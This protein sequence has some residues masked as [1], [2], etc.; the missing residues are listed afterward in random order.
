VAFLLI[1]KRP[2]SSKTIMLF[3]SNQFAIIVAGGSGS[4]MGAAMPKQFIEV[5]QK[6]ILMHTIARFF[7]Y[8]ASLQLILVL[9]AA[10][11]PTWRALCKKH[12]FNVPVALVAGGQT[13]F[14]S[15]KNGLNSIEASE[16]LVAVHDGVRPFVTPQLIAQGFAAAAQKG[17][18]VTAVAL[19]DS[20]RIVEDGQNKAVNRAAY[21]LMQTPQTFRLD[22]LRHAFE[23][24]EQ[25]FFTDCASVAEHAGYDI[26]LIEGLYENI[27]ITTPEDL[28]W[29]TAF[30]QTQ[31]A[32][33]KS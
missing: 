3:D 5:A 14:Q 33:K 8:S 4:R 29:A 21:R 18:A 16:G 24:P 10:E 23:Q 1:K 31:F 28:L 25:P 6:P 17:A 13:R 26:T 30:F 9:P 15:V 20:M 19:K 11:I 22:W 32:A 2:F 12:R 27:K 7:S